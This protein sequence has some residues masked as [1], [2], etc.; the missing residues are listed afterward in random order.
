MLKCKEMHFSDEEINLDLVVERLKHENN[1]KRM[2]K[3]LSTP[4]RNNHS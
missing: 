3:S 2:K 1:K 4:P